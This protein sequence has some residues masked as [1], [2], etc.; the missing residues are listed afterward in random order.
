[1]NIAEQFGK[2]PAYWN[3]RM[4]GELN[5]FALKAV[6]LKGEFIWHHHDI[7]EELFLVVKGT[8]RMRFRDYGATVRGGDLSIASWRGA[9]ARGGR[10]SASSFTGTECPAEHGKYHQRKDCSPARATLDS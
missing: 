1:M 5:D 4:I 8:L 3:A 7:E 2:I 10:G 9:S 6:K